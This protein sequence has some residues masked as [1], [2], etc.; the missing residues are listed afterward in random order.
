MIYPKQLHEIEKI[1]ELRNTAIEMDENDKKVLP[2]LALNE[3]CFELFRYFHFVFIIF[4]G[5]YR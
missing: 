1:P 2:F 5:F 4:L 3:V